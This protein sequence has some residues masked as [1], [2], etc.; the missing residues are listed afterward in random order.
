MPARAPEYTPITPPLKDF[1]LGRFPYDIEKH[2]TKH[3]M[4]PVHTVVYFLTQYR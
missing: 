1:T 3:T 2:L 4:L